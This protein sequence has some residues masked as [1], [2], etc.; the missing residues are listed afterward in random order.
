MSLFSS[1]L[2]SGGLSFLRIGGDLS[3]IHTHNMHAHSYTNSLLFFFFIS[4]FRFNSST[5][6]FQEWIHRSLFPETTGL[7]HIS[8]SGEM[9]ACPA[10][11]MARGLSDVVVIDCPLT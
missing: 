3:G 4:D 7:L 2:R 11:Q 5:V 8:T 10:T 6:C 1:L 9:L